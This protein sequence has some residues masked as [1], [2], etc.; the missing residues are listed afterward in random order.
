MNGSRILVKIGMSTFRATLQDNPTAFE[1][2]LP[3]TVPM[4]ELNGN[5]KYADLL[6]PLDHFNCKP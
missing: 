2:L 4:T 6:G 5:E 1:A 3:L